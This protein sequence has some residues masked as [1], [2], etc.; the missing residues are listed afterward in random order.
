NMKA[1]GKPTSELAEYLLEEAHVATVAGDGFGAPG[2]LRL[3]YVCEE[4]VIREGI[5]KIKK[6]LEKLSI[7]Q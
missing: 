2:Y 5:E 7:T 4:D 3:S 6:A 1:F